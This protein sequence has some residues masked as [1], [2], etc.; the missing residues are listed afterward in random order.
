MADSATD[1][2]AGT[3]P[4]ATPSPGSGG[5]SKAT[6]TGVDVKAGTTQ[7][8]GTVAADPAAIAGFDWKSQN[9]A[10]DDIGYLQT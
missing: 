5:E 1:L 6:T 2:L 8:G 4:P 7:G 10:D 9:L 3:P